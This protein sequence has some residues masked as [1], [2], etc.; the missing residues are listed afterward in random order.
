MI[1]LL[2]IGLIITLI[3]G[4]T[5]AITPWISVLILLAGVY[6]LA[7]HLRQKH[8][9][10]VGLKNRMRELAASQAIALRHLGGLNLPVET[11]VNLF[12]LADRLVVESDAFH[13][14]LLRDQQPFLMLL[15]DENRHSI[16]ES[17]S[18]PPGDPAGLRLLSELKERIRKHDRSI[19]ANRILLLLYRLDQPV[20]TAV[21]FLTGL[22]QK[23]IR[24]ILSRSGW[25]LDNGR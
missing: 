4:T 22:R 18:P 2:V 11:P 6:V 10:T 1:L 5:G 14:E 25:N 19:R 3:L 8:A 24:Q 13:Q 12:L 17:I 7:W 16:L 23:Q 15:T 9:L 20:P 21:A